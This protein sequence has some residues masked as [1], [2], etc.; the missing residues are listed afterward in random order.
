MGAFPSA[1]A[2][3]EPFD[4]FK[5]RAKALQ[6]QALQDE[7]TQRQQQTASGALDLQMKQRQQQDQQTI[8]QVAAAHNGNLAAA[9]PELAGKVSAAT[10]IPLQK[11]IIDTQKS[12]AELDEKNLANEK[13][14][15]DQLLGLVTQAKQLPPDQYAQV[16]PSLAQKAIEIEPRLKGHVDPAQPVPQQGLDQLAL[17]FATHSQL[18]GVEAENR[19][20]AKAT[21][22]AAKAPSELAESQAKASL[23]QQQAAAGGT[24]DVDKYIANYLKEKNLP[25]TAANWSRAHKAYTDETKTDPG[26][27]RAIAFAANRPV[28]IIDPNNPNQVKYDS[29]GNAIKTGAATPASASFTTN[30]AELKSELPTKIGD[31]KVAFT[32]M[33]QHAQ[34]LRDAAKALDNG[35]V[36]TLAGLKNTFKNEFGYEGPITASAIADAYKGEVSN[37]IN[38]GHITDQG[39]EKIAHTLDPSKQNYQTL[40]SVLGAYQNLAQS[41]MNMLNKQIQATQDKAQ[42]KQTADQPAA[43]D[44]FSSFGGKTRQ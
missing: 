27:A 6:T 26:I 30:K 10:F 23:T 43:K 4:P 39:N 34:L 29:A 42:G 15:S 35:D 28:Q 40:D 44:P 2:Q 16:W 18:A 32:T 1:A 9:M 17:G 38:K 33:I 19:A 12:Y 41:K 8:M 36:Q 11:S 31:Q 7:Q 3:A 20:K 21:Q 13:S 5:Y 25:N 22:E 37:V 24:G 14:R